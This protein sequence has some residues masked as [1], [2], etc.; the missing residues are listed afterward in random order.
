MNFPTYLTQNKNQIKPVALI[1]DT[2]QYKL[3]HFRPMFHLR[4]NQVGFYKQNVTLPQVL[5]RHFPSKNQL[6]GL[7][8]NGTLVENGLNNITQ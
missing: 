6:P 3:T 1:L 4:I 5:F 2:V 8:V 7:P